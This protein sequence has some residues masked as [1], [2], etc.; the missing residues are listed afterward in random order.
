MFLLFDESCFVLVV[1][2]DFLSNDFRCMNRIPIVAVDSFLDVLVLAGDLLASFLSVLF[3][4][5]CRCGLEV[6][7]FHMAVILLE[8]NLYG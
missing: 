1:L 7:G 4:G 8:V 6:P 5:C 3:V 2:G